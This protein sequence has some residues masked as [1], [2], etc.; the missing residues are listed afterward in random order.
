MPSSRPPTRSAA[1]LVLARLAE[2]Q[3]ELAETLP[4]DRLLLSGRGGP[5][6]GVPLPVGGGHRRSLPAGVRR[7]PR[8]PWPASARSTGTRPWPPPPWTPAPRTPPGRCAAGSA[9]SWS[10]SRCGTCSAWPTSRRWAGSWPP[11]PRPAWRRRCG[12][13]RPAVPMAVIGMGKL[14]GRE[15][16]YASDVDVLFVHDG[17]GAEAERAARSRARHHGLTR[18]PRH[19]VPHRRRPPA[20]RTGRRAVAH[21][22]RLPG[23]TGTSGPRPGSSRP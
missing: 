13:R 15:L 10:G 8:P 12:W 22:R 21:A 20:R 3:P 18:P 9:R 19:R 2:A 7:R 14:G 17:A 16:N 11:W 5:G 4:E 6:R 23:A 1:R